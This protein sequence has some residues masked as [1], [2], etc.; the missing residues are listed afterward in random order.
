MKRKGYLIFTTH[1]GD[2][3]DATF[4]TDKKLFD[5]LYATGGRTTKGNPV[6]DAYMIWS[7]D[8][9]RNNAKYY[10]KENR[11]ATQTYCNQPWPFND[12]EVLGT[13]YLLVY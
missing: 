2:E 4:I 1:D 7:A 3:V 10:K 9:Q 13:Y 8:V 12:V 11:W 6:D 5:K